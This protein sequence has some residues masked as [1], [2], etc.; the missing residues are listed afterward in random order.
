MVILVHRLIEE[1]NWSEFTRH[2]PKFPIRKEKKTHSAHLTSV[3]VFIRNGLHAYTIAPA[4]GVA[5][6]GHTKRAGRLAPA[7]PQPIMALGRWAVDTV[8]RASWPSV[9]LK[10]FSFFSR[11]YCLRFVRSTQILTYS[12]TFSLRYHRRLLRSHRLLRRLLPPQRSASC[13]AATLLLRL[14]PPP[15]LARLQCCRLLEKMEKILNGLETSVN[16]L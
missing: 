16:E 7:A 5:R 15:A 6:G 14:S 12:L 3:H 4:P 13:C 9:G 11:F 2:T 8:S 1:K 10:K